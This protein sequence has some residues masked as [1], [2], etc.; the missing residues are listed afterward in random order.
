[1]ATNTEINYAQEKKGYINVLLGLL[2]LTAVTFIQPHMFLT[3]HNFAI[4]MLIGLVKAWMILMYYM[5]L[6]GEKLIGA[7]VIFSVG[8]VI[9]F[10]V[11][12]LLD[13]ANFQFAN[14]SHITNEATS[15]G[16]SVADRHH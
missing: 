16:K 15:S 4:Q 14:E 10:F 2:V 11:V 1:M 13:V 5:H 6:K 3:D 9:F 7:T 12:V 8:L